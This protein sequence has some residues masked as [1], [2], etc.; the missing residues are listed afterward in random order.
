MEF[1]LF[2]KILFLNIVDFL[3]SINSFNT[4]NILIKM[5]KMKNKNFNFSKNEKG[6]R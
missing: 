3:A 1:P 5:K 6:K 2:H 4:Y